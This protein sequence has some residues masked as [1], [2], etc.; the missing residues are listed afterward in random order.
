[1]KAIGVLCARVRV[2]EK[3]IIAA[4][5]VAGGAGMPVP[6][7][8][9]PLP[10]GPASLDLATLG[11]DSVGETVPSLEAVIDRCQSR[12]IAAITLPIL[13][14]AGIRV[15]DAGIAAAGSRLDVARVLAL[16]GIPRPASLIGFSEESGNAAAAQLGYPS[17]LLPLLPGSA[18]TSL[19]DADTADAVIEHRIVLG[20]ASEALVL[21]QA[22]APGEG[23]RTRVHVVG[24]RAIAFEGA[25]V[26]GDALAMAEAAA[27]AVG[28]SLVTV[29]LAHAGGETV[30]WDLHPVADFRRAQNLGEQ[31]VAS[32]I[33]GLVT[34]ASLSANGAER[35]L[36]E[37][38]PRAIWNAEVR[39]GVVL[40]A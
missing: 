8:S 10:P 27:H 37:V 18:T 15:L 32:A 4:V 28:A 9:T 38:P 25:A 30:V 22:G 40:S 3:Q 26:G 24:G 29:E 6:P 1:M 2:E 33:A 36:G 14:A 11:V 16:A 31:S 5:G 34:E 17:T 12:T 21:M 39:H 7:P 19:L 13:R 20:T 35:H 23:E